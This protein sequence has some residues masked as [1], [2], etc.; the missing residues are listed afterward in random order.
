[1]SPPPQ[2]ATLVHVNTDDMGQWLQ[3]FDSYVGSYAKSENFELDSIFAPPKTL[4]D[5]KPHEI[6]INYRKFVLRSV[7]L[8]HEMYKLFGKVL[9]CACHFTGEFCH[10]QVL[11]TMINEIF[12]RGSSVKWSEDVVFFK[13]GGCCLSNFYSYPMEDEKNIL[14][15]SAIQMFVFKQFHERGEKDFATASLMLNAHDAFALMGNFY[16]EKKKSSADVVMLTIPVEIRLMQEC[17]VTKWERCP[18]FH[19]WASRHAPIIDFAEAAL[20]TFWGCGMDIMMMREGDHPRKMPGKNVLGWLIKFIALHK[21][22]QE[23]LWQDE[24][25]QIENKSFLTPFET[26]LWMVNRYC[27]PPEKECL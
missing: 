22:G 5:C 2:E 12:H 3:P 18:D 24:I 17:L 8:R 27:T 14:F 20:N 9:A 26:G 19:R 11:T 4:F 16:R 1:M 21:I 10:A 15:Q 25:K 13:G 23:H 7:N 6:P